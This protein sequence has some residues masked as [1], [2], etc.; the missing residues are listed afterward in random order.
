MRETHMS[1]SHRR[2]RNRSKEM[3][4]RAIQDRFFQQHI[5]EDLNRAENKTN[6]QN[7]FP[8]TTKVFQYPRIKTQL[9]KIIPNKQYNLF[10]R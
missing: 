1:H 4:D 3:N 8:S 9:V 7:S 6:Y 2:N 10:K 5:K